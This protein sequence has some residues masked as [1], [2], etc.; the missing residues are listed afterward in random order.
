MRLFPRA[1]GYE[2]EKISNRGDLHMFRVVYD[3]S[4]R[5][6]SAIIKD[7]GTMENLMGG[8]G[9]ITKL[10]SLYD[11]TMESLEHKYSPMVQKRLEELDNVLQSRTEETELKISLSGRSKSFWVIDR[12][13]L[14]WNRHTQEIHFCLS[15]TVKKKKD[16]NHQLFRME[17]LIDAP[18]HDQLELAAEQ[19]GQ[20]EETKYDEES[21]SMIIKEEP[22]TP[23]VR[24][25]KMQ[26]CVVFADEGGVAEDRTPTGGS[27]FVD[28]HS[29]ITADTGDTSNGDANSI[30]HSSMKRPLAEL[31]LDADS[32]RPRRG[33]RSHSSVKTDS[34]HPDTEASILKSVAPTASTFNP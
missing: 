31:D 2:A 29:N 14:N 6:S 22:I 28:R 10:W 7:T 20:T 32:K 15:R 16:D 5:R 34:S 17:L 4:K 24:S 18:Y 19:P 1:D 21:G 3:S 9:P 23:P 25:I 8:D 27:D 33:S 11:E 30:G 26:H 13:R 12:R